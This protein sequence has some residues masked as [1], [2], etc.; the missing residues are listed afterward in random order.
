MPATERGKVRPMLKSHNLV[1][2]QTFTAIRHEL[3]PA[4]DPKG[5]PVEGLFNAWIALD[6]PSQLNSYTTDAVKEVILALR[7]A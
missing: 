5:K 4:L 3:R 6:N 7:Q 1:P 2:D